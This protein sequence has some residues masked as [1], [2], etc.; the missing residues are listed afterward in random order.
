MWDTISFETLETQ[1]NEIIWWLTDD[2]IINIIQDS[3]VIFKELKNKYWEESE[4]YKNAKK[5]YIELLKEINQ[6]KSEQQQ[7]TENNLIRI[8]SEYNDIRG[9]NNQTQW[10][11]RK[12]DRRLEN[13]SNK[14]LTWRRHWKT[15]SENIEDFENKL[16][17]LQVRQINWVTLASYIK[18]LVSEQKLEKIQITE[19]LLF[20]LWNWNLNLWIKKLKDLQKIWSTNKNSASANILKKS[21]F[22]YIVDWVINTWF[23]EILESNYSLS[24]TLI[25]NFTDSK[26]LDD[27]KKSLNNEYTR[28]KYLDSTLD[29]DITET[30]TPSLEVLSYWLWLEIKSRK[31]I[32]I[33]KLVKKHKLKEDSA[34]EI[35]S[36]LENTTS[37]ITMVN[38]L[39]PIIK[40]ASI[41]ELIGLIIWIKEIEIRQENIEIEIAK[42]EAWKDQE[43]Q[44]KVEEKKEL[45]ERKEFEVKKS[46]IIVRQLTENDYKKILELQEKW[47]TD[48]KSIIET[49]RKGNKSLDNALKTFEQNPKENSTSLA[50]WYEIIKNKNSQ[51]VES[52]KY[53][54]NWLIK[55]IDD[56]NESEKNLLSGNKENAEKS[57]KSIINFVEILDKLNVWFLWKYRERLFR[58]I[59][60]TN[61]LLNEKDINY[62]NDEEIKIFLVK[63]LKTLCK[64]SWNNKVFWEFCFIDEKILLKKDLKEIENMIK[65]INLENQWTS[66]NWLFI[67]EE[68][69][70]KNF[71][72]QNWKFKEIEFEQLLSSKNES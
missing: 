21:W 61:L 24:E 67:I 56:F 36:K 46:K 2:L 69:F 5:E 20:I 48:E 17:T 35:Y 57:S 34:L 70:Y 3:F 50:N 62:L 40:V 60:K 42:R 43:K 64:T 68:T 47:I 15:F 53:E 58:S 25:N 22:W 33:N 26:S 45:L 51:I 16:W 55:S 37:V 10:L 54:S 14:M 7:N 38:I 39:N 1:T 30:E 65:Q 63:I 4:K 71:I 19:R 6:D 32:I 49:L 11:W 66:I 29:I 44:K 13:L 12:I 28:K 9:L 27:F 41:K 59:K 23:R 52:L 72:D 31:D 18:Y 8:I